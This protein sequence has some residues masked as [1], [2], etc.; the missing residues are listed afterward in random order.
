MEEKERC[1][2]GKWFQPNYQATLKKMTLYQHQVY[3]GFVGF[4]RQSWN[5]NLKDTCEFS[6]TLDLAKSNPWIGYSIQE[7]LGFFWGTGSPP[8][9]M[10]MLV[11]KHIQNRFYFTLY[12]WTF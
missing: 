8:Y 6:P 2:V 9:Y 12:P 1:R 11:F 4:I 5:W 3:V 7:E 10:E